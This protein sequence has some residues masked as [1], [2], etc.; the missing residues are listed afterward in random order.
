MLAKMID[1]RAMHRG[2]NARG[3]RQ[4]SRSSDFAAGR[5]KGNH[6]SFGGGHKNS[7]AGD[8]WSSRLVSQRL[9]PNQLARF[10]IDSHQ[11]LSA[12]INDCRV[13]SSFDRQSKRRRER[14]IAD[15]PA[16]QNPT[17]QGIQ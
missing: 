15:M 11:L 5:L 1:V 7:I 10:A 9:P 3:L 14:L 13:G 16:P 2:S 4:L 6:A 8:D 12:G 17:T